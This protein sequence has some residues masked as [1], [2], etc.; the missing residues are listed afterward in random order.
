M[1]MKNHALNDLETKGVSFLPYNILRSFPKLLRRAPFDIIIIDPPTFQEPTPATEVQEHAPAAELP[2]ARH[3]F[4]F[5]ILAL[6]LGID[7]EKVSQKE[8]ETFASNIAQ[9]ALLAIEELLKNSRHR[10]DMLAELGLTELSSP[11]LIET[12]ST[13]RDLAVRLKDPDGRILEM[14]RQEMEAN[15]LHQTV[16]VGATRQTMK[17]LYEEF[18]PERLYFRFEKENRL[19]KSFTNKKSLAWD[20]YCETFKDLDEGANTQFDLQ[21]IQA[22]YQE[23]MRTFS[24]G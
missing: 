22:A 2:S 7:S 19:S 16:F 3:D 12:V 4:I 15:R 5:K 13:P 24:S 9:L 1:G 14:I 20:A 11:S 18:S 6:A 10:T 21:K 23:L 17:H 8:Q